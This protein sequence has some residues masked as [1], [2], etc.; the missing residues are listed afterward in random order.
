MSR[1]RLTVALSS[2]GQVYSLPVPW[3]Q[4]RSRLFQLFFDLF[5][6]TTLCAKS[7]EGAKRPC[8]CSVIISMCKETLHVLVF[9]TCRSTESSIEESFI[10][11]F[12]LKQSNFSF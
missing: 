11:D 8:L 1:P 2:R 9:Y 5:M 6:K 7:W 4:V 3:I 12:T 10:K